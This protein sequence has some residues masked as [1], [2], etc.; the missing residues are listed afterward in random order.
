MGVLLATHLILLTNVCERTPNDQF[1]PIQN[2]ATQND[3]IPFCQRHRVQRPERD[4]LFCES[5]AQR[6]LTASCTLVPR[7]SV[8]L[9][10]Q[11]DSALNSNCEQVIS[12]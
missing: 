1:D 12:I 3:T 5:N 10:L 4:I 6:S 2:T 7:Q 8:I 11:R 9:G